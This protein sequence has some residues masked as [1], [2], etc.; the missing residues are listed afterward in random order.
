MDFY[1]LRF[2]DKGIALT[3]HKIKALKE[4][5]TPKTA[6]EL[7]SFLG[8][9]TYCSRSTPNLASISDKLW[10]LTRNKVKW[11]WTAE[12]QQQTNIN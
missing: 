12:H 5:K 10:K 3:E 2:S 9:A 8:L 1:G 11:H 7:R 4:A 6:S